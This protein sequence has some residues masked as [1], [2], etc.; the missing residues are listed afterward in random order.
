MKILI[1]ILILLNMILYGNNIYTE[2]EVYYDYNSKPV[3]FRGIA[4][5]KNTKKLITGIIKKYDKKTGHLIFE[6]EYENGKMNGLIKS[7]KNGWLLEESYYKDGKPHGTFK[8]Y[9]EQKRLIAECKM[10]NG[11]Q[12][13]ISRMYSKTG[14]IIR[15]SKFNEGN[16]V[17]FRRYSD[18]GVLVKEKLFNEK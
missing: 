13:G 3:V 17:Y 11:R 10:E 16:M 12:H 7:Y 14:V 8:M 2:E 18:D 1:P 5:E 4:H 9:D 15:E 6:A